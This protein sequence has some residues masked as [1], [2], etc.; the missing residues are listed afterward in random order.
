MVPRPL[1]LRGFLLWTISLDGGN[2]GKYLDTVGFIPLPDFIRGM[3]EH[4]I[5]LIGPGGAVRRLAPPPSRSLQRC[6]LPQ[7]DSEASVRCDR[8]RWHQVRMRGRARSR[9]H[10]R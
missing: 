1:R 9:R 5:G 6:M 7:R 8:S 4:Q 3:S 2:A 10:S